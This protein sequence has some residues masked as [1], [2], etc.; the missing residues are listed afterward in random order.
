MV[1]HL[2]PLVPAADDDADR[3]ERSDRDD[4]VGRAGTA[5]ESVLRW[6]QTAIALLDSGAIRRPGGNVH[7]P[8]VV[9]FH[10]D[11]TFT[12]SMA[13]CPL[14]E[15]EGPLLV[16]ERHKVFVSCGYVEGLRCPRCAA[17]VKAT[18]LSDTACTVR[19]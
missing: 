9:I 14:G 1:H 5:G 2:E 13:E 16:A 15:R 4:Q 17:E 11:G 19:A 7:C 12:C 6:W 8:G 10:L 3:D 18:R